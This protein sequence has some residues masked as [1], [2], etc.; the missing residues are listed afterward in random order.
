MIDTPEFP[1]NFKAEARSHIAVLEALTS[2]TSDVDWFYVS[3]PATFGAY[4]PGERT[5]TYRTSDDILLVDAEG[6]SSI[7]GADYAIAFVDE[8]ET[9]THHRARFTVGY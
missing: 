3:P 7:S 6:N 1:E 2:S 5:G 8:I 9:P 4:A